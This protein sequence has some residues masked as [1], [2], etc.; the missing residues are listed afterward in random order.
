MRDSIKREGGKNESKRVKWM[1]NEQNY[2]F[3]GKRNEGRKTLIV[4]R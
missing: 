3:E 2:Y 4:E 1:K